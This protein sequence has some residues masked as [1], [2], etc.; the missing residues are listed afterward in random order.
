MLIFAPCIPVSG[1]DEGEEVSV[2]SAD[3]LQNDRI[4]FK[5][6]TI[7]EGQ[8]VE[9]QKTL[10]D[11]PNR[12]EIIQKNGTT[13]SIEDTGQIASI[14]MDG[15]KLDDPLSRGG[16]GKLL[17]MIREFRDRSDAAAQEALR[18]SLS[19]VVDWVVG[20][21]AKNEIGKDKMLRLA[22]GHRIYSGEE[23]Q[24]RANCRIRLR[25]A[26]RFLLGLEEGTQMQIREIEV[27]PERNRFSVEFEL[28]RGAAWVDAPPELSARGP[29]KVDGDGLRFELAEGLF[30]FEQLENGDLMLSHFRGPAAQVEHVSKGQSVDLPSDSRLLFS[31]GMLKGTEELEPMRSPIDEP[32]KWL[33]FTDWQPLEFDLPVQFTLVGRPKMQPRPVVPILGMA[34]AKF[35]FQDLQP[36]VV[37]GLA[38]LL[39][40]YRRGIKLFKDDVGRLPT[41]EEGLKALREAPEG[42]ETWNGP[43]LSEDVP[44]ADPWGHSLQYSHIETPTS[45]LVNLYSIGEN[46]VDEDG[47]GDDL[48]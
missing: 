39:Q 44:E 16:R 42:V 19:A 34:S 40:A 29:I 32:D 9:G 17:D 31:A 14:E 5:N 27:D 6:G 20:D 4:F 25:M 45:K 47:L 46:G 30:Q 22:K 41:V 2:R 21:S 13:V 48:R 12:Y 23:V 11:D 10:I 28:I 35:V 37:T 43:Y 8:I 26:D 38:P 33:E 3:S 36:I 18:K 15:Q 1:Q 7:F 24:T